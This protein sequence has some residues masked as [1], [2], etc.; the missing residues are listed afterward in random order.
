MPSAVNNPFSLSF[1]TAGA[2]D[3]ITQTFNIISN[4]GSAILRLT[5]TTNSQTGDL[6]FTGDGSVGK[7]KMEFLN[8]YFCLNGDSLLFTQGNRMYGG[9][10]ADTT[11][12]SIDLTNNECGILDESGN[13]IFSAA[14]KELSDGS[15]ISFAWKGG[16]G[17]LKDYSAV[18]SPEEGM[19][20]FD[21]TAHELVYHNGTAW[22]NL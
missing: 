10:F 6:Q 16:A 18:S 12:Y 19:I 2:I 17:L 13:T 3:V 7:G 11:S 5:D 14:N 21:F 8:A 9:D 20:A 4:A 1:Y 22:V 15:T